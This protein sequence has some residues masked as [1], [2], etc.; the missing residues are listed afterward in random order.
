MNHAAPAMAT[1][2][3]FKPLLVHGKW[4]VGFLTIHNIEPGTELMWDSGKHRVSQ[5][6]RR[7]LRST[8]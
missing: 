3:P 2:R 4:R 1:V 5:R 8:S 6:K 7:K